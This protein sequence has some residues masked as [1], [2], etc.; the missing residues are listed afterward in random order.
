[1]GKLPDTWTN[2]VTVFKG[3]FL[4]P[5]SRTEATQAFMNL[6]IRKFESSLEIYVHHT[7]TQIRKSGLEGT[8]GS[9]LV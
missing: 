6:S 9:L 2:F 3:H 8:I 1:M 4:Q 7:R 5:P